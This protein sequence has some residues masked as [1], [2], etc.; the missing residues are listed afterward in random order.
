MSKPECMY[1]L[2]SRKDSV[3]R[4]AP[5]WEEWYNRTLK[6]SVCGWPDPKKYTKPK[7]VDVVVRQ[8]PRGSAASADAF[9]KLLTQDLYDLLAPYCKHLFAGRC[10]FQRKP[11]DEPVETPYVTVYTPR[12]HV[13]EAHRGKYCRHHR[14][15]GCGKISNAVFWAS[16]AVV[17]RDLDERGVYQDVFG[18]V[19][20]RSLL[21]ETLKLERKFPDLKLYR[22]SIFDEPHDG[23]VLPGDPGWTGVLKERRFPAPPERDPPKSRWTLG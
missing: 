4:Y 19:Y 14:C 11:G 9:P 6:C 3:V 12:E 23:D 15:K 18:N 2:F 1:E 8:M 17:R 13:L 10:Y 5:Q 16:G 21:A 7:G 20:V 22:V